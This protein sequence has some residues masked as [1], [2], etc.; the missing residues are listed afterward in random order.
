MHQQKPNFHE[1]TVENFMDS[2][3]VFNYIAGKHNQVSLND[4]ARQQQLIEEEVIEG[5]DAVVDNDV[6][7]VLDACMDV[8]VTTFGLLQKLE[9]LGVDVSK[10]MQKTAD[11]NLSKYCK[12]EQEAFDTSDMYLAKGIST[13]I[14]Y[15]S[16]FDVFVIKNSDTGK[17]LKPINFVPNDLSDCVPQELILKGFE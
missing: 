2:C 14:K 13:H 1:F 6:V 15:N 17:I 10:A 16:E 5:S 3:E 7:E 12:T 11:N 4:I 8:L 9:Y